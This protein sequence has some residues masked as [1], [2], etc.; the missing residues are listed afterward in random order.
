MISKHAD[1]IDKIILMSENQLIKWLSFGGH[2]FKRWMLAALSDRSQAPVPQTCQDDGR[3][4]SSKYSF[5][6]DVM[7]LN[8]ELNRNISYLQSI[9]TCENKEEPIY[10]V[11]M[12]EINKAKLLR[13]GK[14]KTFMDLCL[15]AIGEMKPFEGDMPVNV[16][17]L[18]G[19]WSLLDIEVQKHRRV[20]DNILRPQAIRSPYRSP[21]LAVKGSRKQKA[22]IEDRNRKYMERMR[23]LKERNTKNIL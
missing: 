15:V 16:G 19:Y 11:A 5:L 3:E 14:M 6:D 1:A 18:E 23:K 20:M 8:D 21:R 22:N 13:R 4:I 12:C 10:E 2:L 9:L 17:D 7:R